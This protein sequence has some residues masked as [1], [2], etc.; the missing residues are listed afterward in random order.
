MTQQTGYY[1][2]RPK[3]NA[4][5]F[6]YPVPSVLR[7]ILGPWAEPLA[8]M[9]PYLGQ[10][11]M[12][13]ASFCNAPPPPVNLTDIELLSLARFGPIGGAHAIPAITMWIQ[14]QLWSTYCEFNPPSDPNDLPPPSPPATP[15]PP[16]PPNTALPPPPDPSDPTTYAVDNETTHGMLFTILETCKWIQKHQ[17]VRDFRFDE[18]FIISESGYK[19]HGLACGYAIT[20]LGIPSGVGKSNATVPRYFSA[21]FVSYGTRYG[22]G[23]YPILAIRDNVRLARE[24]ML[25]WTDGFAADTFTWEL[26][27][28]VS[29]QVTPLI[30]P[31]FTDQS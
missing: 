24:N 27:P 19:S 30:W 23:K 28:G 22:F 12:E 3:A 11:T 21:G 25:I 10:A 15:L 26:A 2:S 20:L 13:T 4:P 8:S 31:D 5:D 9:I 16:I 6:I 14:G 17:Q 18:P 1:G 29:A 7:Q